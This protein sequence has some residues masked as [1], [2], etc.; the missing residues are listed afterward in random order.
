MMGKSILLPLI[1]LLLMPF[2]FAASQGD[3]GDF[4]DETVDSMETQGQLWLEGQ[5]AGLGTGG[6]VF[7]SLLETFSPSQCGDSWITTT[8]I[9]GTWI[10]PVALT[11]MI[12]V[13]G[14][15]ILYM[16]GQLFSSPN[17]IAISKEEAFQLGL[18]VSKL[19]IIIAVL[20]S[21]ELWYRIASAGIAD[22]VYANNNT[23]IDA[24]MAFS[25][26]MAKEMIDHYSMLLIYNMVIHTIFSSTMWFGVTWRAMYSFNLGPVL[27]P[28]IDIVGSA[29]QF[30]SLGV[31]EWMLHIITLCILK[32]WAWGL[33]IPVGIL[34]R[35]IPYTRGGGEALLSLTFALILF[36]PFMFLFDYEVH[37]VMKYN[38]TDAKHAMGAFLE[39]S[40]LLAVFGTVLIMVF[41]LAGVFVPF[42]LGGAL[43]LV[44]ELIRSA[45]YYIVIMSLLL[46]FLN[47]FI[48]L[49]AAKE[50]AN[51]SRVDVNFL[52]FLKII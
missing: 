5:A 6:A 10:A 45:V 15:A 38:L 17:L 29:L 51:F 31:S 1:L 28:L 35:S 14:I 50:M 16:A 37:K 30:L 13:I 42:F 34:L 46:P 47:I 24:S 20:N 22:P 43:S 2:S 44:F 25:R 33:F 12:V 49:T 3:M 19:I 18:T 48:T 39:K 26:L 11:I 7:G 27:K 9:F 52:S 23:M 4:F 41:L 32:K 8:N 40:G 36:Y 21:G